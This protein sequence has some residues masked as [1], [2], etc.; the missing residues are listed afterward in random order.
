MPLVATSTLAFVSPTTGL[1]LSLLVFA[2]AILA[3]KLMAD[4]RKCTIASY[5]AFISS[6]VFTIIRLTAFDANLVVDG[7]IMLLVVGYVFW[8]LILP[9]LQG[10]G[11]ARAMKQWKR[12]KR[13]KEHE[14]D[15]EEDD[16]PA[17]K[18]NKGLVDGDDRRSRTPSRSKHSPKEPR[19]EKTTGKTPAQSK[20]KPSSK[21]KP[22]KKQPAGNTG[23]KRTPPQEK[24]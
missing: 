16:M 17:K 3:A 5:T 14:D 4:P 18:K 15:Y 20:S 6:I 21:S 13:Q 22:R 7:L 2:G 8:W 10:G 12:G 1:F 19:K 11:E 24:I 23:E 9:L